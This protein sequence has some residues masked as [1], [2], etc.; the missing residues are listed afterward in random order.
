[1]AGGASLP[2]RPDIDGKLCQ[3]CHICAR[4]DVGDTAR[5]GHGPPAAGRAWDGGLQARRAW[6]RHREPRANTPPLTQPFGLSHARTRTR[7]PS[8]TSIAPNARRPSCT[9]ESAP[10]HRARACF[11]AHRRL[12]R[13]RPLPYP[14][15]QKRRRGKCSPAAARRYA[16]VS[17]ILR[18]PSMCMC[19]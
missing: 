16:M 1:M 8:R 13:A 17:A 7:L 14:P 11:P 18:P 3:L 12:V 6:A 15:G 10:S 4:G 9:G 19:Q 2:A 5:E